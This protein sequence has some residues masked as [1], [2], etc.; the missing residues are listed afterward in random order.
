LK[1]LTEE[2]VIVSEGINKFHKLLRFSY[3]SNHKD[4]PRV[5]KIA[6]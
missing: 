2:K 5:A 1:R 3:G 4:H 6:A